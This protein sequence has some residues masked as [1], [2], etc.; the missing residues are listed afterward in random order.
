MKKIFVFCFVLL[1]TGLL[2]S[3]V[4]DFS[5]IRSDIVYDT[6]QSLTPSVVKASNGDLVCCLGIGDSDEPIGDASPGTL[7]AFSR[8]TDSGQNWSEPYL[9]M[10]SQHGEFGALGG[11]L[12]TAPDG[13]IYLAM[14]DFLSIGEISNYT[15]KTYVL[16]SS[17]N[18]QTFTQ[19]AVV[20]TDA[21]DIEPI[22]AGILIANNGDWL[23]PAYLLNRDTPSEGVVCGFYRST[24][25]GITWTR[26]ERAFDDV[27]PG[28][29]GYKA[30]N[31][32]DIVVRS[33]GSLLAVARTD[34]VDSG[35]PY[36]KGQLYYVESFDDGYTWTSPQLVGIPGHSPALI[37]LADGTIML[38][39]R[40]LSSSGNKTSVYISQ[41]GVNF[42]YAFDSVNPRPNANSATGYPTFALIDEN[43]IYM[44]YY[45][46]DTSLPW[47]VP[48]YSAGN[49]IY[50]DKLFENCGTYGYLIGDI[51]NN[52]RI[53]L[54]DFLFIAEN[55]LMS[56]DPDSPYFI[57]CSVI[58][59]PLCQ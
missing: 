44:G 22:S 9:V 18:G 14:N 28:Q 48:T 1:S 46:A 55:W 58:G 34:Q 31:E 27:L 30:F 52:C 15:S 36:S 11:Y 47:P 3:D 26:L 57:D 49:L 12:S 32:V 16:K 19:I 51:N 20:P 35:F 39:C 33:N 53:D 50:Y 2:F 8:S 40:R 13:D 4:S 10:T 24:D 54:F 59:D 7:L 17:D 43:N 37:R 56:T 38:G 21:A 29:E 6:T 42:Q 23:L 25:A 45:T 41:D 5:I